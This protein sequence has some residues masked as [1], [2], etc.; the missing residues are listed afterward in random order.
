MPANILIVEDTESLSLLYQSYLIPTGLNTFVAGT[1]QAALDY[2]S[3]NQP[4]L[5]ILDIMLPDMSGMDILAQL[6]NK[7]RPD[8]IVL[9]AH[10]SKEL[11]VEAIRHGAIDFLEK[12]I[13]AERF[14]ITVNN[15]LKTKNIK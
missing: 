11:A 15:G 3:N 14:R 12:P 8:V 6:P 10:A 2:L 5:I 7:N 1:G 4:D 9:T 13:D